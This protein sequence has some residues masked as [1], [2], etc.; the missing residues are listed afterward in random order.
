MQAILAR[1]LV[2]QMLLGA[3]TYQEVV[4]ARPD[5]KIAIDAYIEEKNLDIDKTK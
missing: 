4:T 5:L 1:Y 2:N 3:L